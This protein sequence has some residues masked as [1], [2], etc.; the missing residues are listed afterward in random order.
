MSSASHVQ[1]VAICTAVLYI[2]Y[3]VT[4]FTGAQKKFA[5]GNRAPEDTRDAVKQDFG[6]HTDS[7]DQAE[8]K[9]EDIRWQ[10][11]VA[12]DLENLPFGLILAWAAVVTNGNS[13]QTS[14]ATIVFTVARVAHTVAYASA[15][16]KARGMAYMVGVL[17][18]LVL[19][20][21]VIAGAF[22]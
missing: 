17:A 10:R 16:P 3:I 19:A 22:K 12:N 6:L 21:N 9:V 14:V 20:E 15:S 2:K 8:A 13:T 11:I 4:T 7:E 18:L 1:V 5:S